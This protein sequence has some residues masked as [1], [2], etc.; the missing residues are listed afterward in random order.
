[1]KALLIEKP[2]Q[3]F[4][5]QTGTRQKSGLNHCIDMICRS[6]ESIGYVSCDTVEQIKS[7]IQTYRPKKVII[8]ALWVRGEGLAPLKNLFPDVEFYC[9]IHSNIPF[10]ALEGPAYL[11]IDSYLK[12]GHGVI[13][14][15]IHAY[16]AFK[17]YNPRVYYLP[18]VYNETFLEPIIKPEDEFLDVGC[19][20]SLRPMKNHLIQ[21]TASINLAKR[22]GKTLRF[23]TNIKR[24]EAGG[25]PVLANLQQLFR[26]NPKH[27]LISQPWMEPVN[28]IQS[29]RKMD[30]NLQVSMSESFNIVAAD[31]IAAGT[32]T[33]VSSEIEWA[34]SK[35]MA[36][37]NDPESI[38]QK[39]REAMGNKDLILENQSKLKE[40]DRVAKEE[41]R[42]FINA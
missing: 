2:H 31:C 9:H 23:H 38:I 29:V 41:W 32:P 28:F 15:S 13:F 37:T 19:F 30:V 22:L 27:Q 17:D 14:N 18:N 21:A 16:N 25:E 5:R 36:R 11:I 4:Q 1:M 12:N 40:F 6:N 3:R 42:K 24:S 39:M 33:V 35:S 7:A 8:Q 26:M 10:L 34:S 20:G